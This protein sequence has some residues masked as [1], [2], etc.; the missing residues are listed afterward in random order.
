[1]E[2][3]DSGETE[4]DLNVFS[5]MT[6]Y[7]NVAMPL[8]QYTSYSDKTIEELVRLKLAL[9]G[10]SGYEDYYLIKKL[11]SSCYDIKMTKCNRVEASRT[12][13]YSS[14]SSATSSDGLQK[15]ETLILP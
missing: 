14:H 4:T 13:G 3:V 2:K 11:G 8:N 10:L 7:E 1:M 6:L 15:I 12:N 9:V 5:S